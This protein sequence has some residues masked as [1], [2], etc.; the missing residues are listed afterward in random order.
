MLSSSLF[1]FVIIIGLFSG[2]IS[3]AIPF[4]VWLLVISFITFGVSFFS[5][6]N[7]K[8]KTYL[9]QGSLYV[10]A[11]VVFAVVMLLMTMNTIPIGVDPNQATKPMG[12]ALFVS[13]LIALGTY[14]QTYYQVT[15]AAE[16][17]KEA[18][19]Y[20]AA[21]GAILLASSLN[22]NNLAL[23]LGALT[24]LVSL[25]FYKKISKLKTKPRHRKK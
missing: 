24:L 23:Y 3:P 20:L 16:M 13:G 19:F 1:T 6:V 18:T 2:N 14:F 12:L 17:F 4:G 9:I 25:V 8:S 10:I 15:K 21:L 11:S 7:G 5:Q 22:D